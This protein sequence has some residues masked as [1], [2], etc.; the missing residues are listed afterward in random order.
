MLERFCLNAAT[1]KSTPLDL[2]IELAR[3]AGAI[4]PAGCRWSRSGDD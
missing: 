1:I 4:P 2:Q 3:E